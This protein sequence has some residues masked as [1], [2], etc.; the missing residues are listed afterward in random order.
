M[1]GCSVM[2]KVQWL[3]QCSRHSPGARPPQTR[4]SAEREL[5][6]QLHVLRLEQHRL[7]ARQGAVQQANI[8]G[9]CR[10]EGV[11]TAQHSFQLGAVNEKVQQVHINEGPSPCYKY[12]NRAAGVH[13]AVWEPGRYE[14]HQKQVRG[15]CMP[16]LRAA[17]STSVLIGVASVQ[18]VVSCSVSPVGQFVN[19]Q[20]ATLKR[21]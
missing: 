15:L 14:P 8:H 9:C 19:W 10:S 4:G 20:F 3:W 18:T 16:R 5:R 6:I 2:T 21:E 12:A 1:T 7:R 17:H 11:S 13:A